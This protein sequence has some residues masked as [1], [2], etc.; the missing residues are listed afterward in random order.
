M[1]KRRVALYT[2]ALAVFSSTYLGYRFYDAQLQPSRTPKA[3]QFEAGD[4]IGST[5]RT[6]LRQPEPL[7]QLPRKIAKESP[8]LSPPV[9]TYTPKQWNRGTIDLVEV[10]SLPTVVTELHAADL[11]DGKTYRLPLPKEKMLLEGDTLSDQEIIYIRIV[12]TPENPPEMR[13]DDPIDPFD[14][15]KSEEPP[16]PYPLIANIIKKPDDT[17]LAQLK[18]WIESVGGAAQAQA[19]IEEAGL[20]DTV[21][22]EAVVVF[23]Q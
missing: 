15:P 13:F 14:V 9:W 21:R 17:S 5:D 11:P 7:N 18:N 20:S 3:G 22:I 8:L 16:S 1:S 23:R 10:I 4:V 6:F 19:L 2:I 12:T